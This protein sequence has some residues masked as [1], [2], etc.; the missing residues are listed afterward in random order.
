MF[1]ENRTALTRSISVLHIPQLT[2]SSRLAQE[3][4]VSPSS[5]H[6][7]IALTRL[8][9]DPTHR[10]TAT[11]QQPKRTK[12]KYWWRKALKWLNS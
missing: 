10:P 7:N 8:V 1:L 3:P 5:S 9:T 2:S 11:T 12:S 4:T 6:E